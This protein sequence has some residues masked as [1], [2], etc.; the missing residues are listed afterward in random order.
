MT[1]LYRL[2]LAFCLTLS[3][4]TTTF[5][6]SDAQHKDGPAP[7]LG[8]DLAVQL[9]IPVFDQN[10][11]DLPIASIGTTPILLKEVWPELQNIQNSKLLSARLQQALEAR[12][13]QESAA[14]AAKKIFVDT[15]ISKEGLLLVEIPLFSDFFP[16]IPVA[17]VNDDPVTVAEFSEDLQS[18]HNEMS[19]HEAATGSKQ[20]I[21]RLMDRLITVRLVEQEARNI[22]FDQ[23]SS[24]QKQ[25]KEFAEKNLLYAL[26]NKQLAGKSLDTEAADELYRQI[27]L[28]GKFENYHFTL[29]KNAVDLLERYNAG[30]DFD[31]LISAAITKKQAAKGTQ[32]E[33]LKFKDLLPNIASEAAKLEAGGISQIFRQA[34]GFLLFRLVD[35][36]FVED[37]QALTYARKNVWERQKAEFASQYT[38]E[39]VDRYSEFDDQAK[40]DLDFSKIKESNPDIKLGEALEP[41]LK[42]QRVLV[43]VNGPTS[44]QLTVADL[45]QKIKAN[46]F[47]GVDIALDAT[48]VDTKQ[49]EILDDTLFRIAGTFESQK[50]GL[51][52]TAKYR[53]EVAEFERR[54]LFDIFMAKVITP[55]IRYGEEEVQGYYDQH[56]ADYMTPAMFKFKSLPFYLQADAEKAAGK[57]H[58]GSD[59]K[60]V[61]ANSEGLVDVQN[62]DLLQFDRN[63]LSLSSLPASL[64]QQ[65]AEVKRGDSLVYAESDNFY[66][67]LYF[68]DV[69]P[70]K[71]RPYDQVRKELLSI[72]YQQKVT[73]TLNEWVEKLKEAYETKV[74]LVV[75]DH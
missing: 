28:Q 64:Q 21:Q 47:H 74:F 31:A 67:V 14:S 72:V 20:N 61:S 52:Q 12:F 32:Q 62:K 19:G 45:A 16:E 65:A 44:V 3:L 39:T 26:L 68:E 25:A 40:D 51:D 13:A 55:D 22:G 17:L 1:H 71:P 60:W 34:D 66:Y 63:I 29:E 30:E 69:F 53:M 49:Q 48:E 73:A 27:S 46:Y 18:V 33:Y 35:Q 36:Q 11:A 4:S 43:T 23:T 70:P 7:V 9:L 41:F 75:K 57:L 8:E 50:L 15:N 24:F 2:L 56:Q 38:T 58:D 54:L 10:F 5:A 42:D 37:P 6:F 59:F